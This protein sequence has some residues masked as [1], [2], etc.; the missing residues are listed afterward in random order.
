M[1]AVAL[2][3]GSIGTAVWLD[4]LKDESNREDARL[5]RDHEEAEAARRARFNLTVA[6]IDVRLGRKT[7][8]EVPPRDPPKADRSTERQVRFAVIGLAIASIAI[9]GLGF[10]NRRTNIVSAAAIVGAV[11]ALLWPYVGAGVTIAVTVIVLIIFFAIFGSLL[12]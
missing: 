6:G 8:E 9:A 2:A 12:G 10:G 4:S 11:I 3:L 1:L 5:L 7:A